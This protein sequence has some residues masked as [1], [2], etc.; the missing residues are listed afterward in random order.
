MSISN[1]LKEYRKSNKISQR[2]L[3][4]ESGVS[5]AYIQQLEKE[6][7]KNP[8][9]DILNKLASALKIDVADLIF[10]DEDRIYNQKDI[11][12]LSEES[13]KFGERTQAEFD[14]RNNKLDN[15]VEELLK[16]LK[17]QIDPVLNPRTGKNNFYVSFQR[18]N[19]RL[20]PDKK[21]MIEDIKKSIIGTVLYHIES[22]KAE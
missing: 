1:K 20:L 7:K 2:Q 18:G 8:S 5:F 10:A 6:E 16:S 15:Q 19:S 4:K 11:D 9:I 13:K 17:V 14:E 12:A 21:D 3:A 22:H